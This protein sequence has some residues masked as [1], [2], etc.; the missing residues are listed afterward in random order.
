[1]PEDG[2]QSQRARTKQGKL[3]A[4]SSVSLHP[5]VPNLAERDWLVIGERGCPSLVTMT[6]IV[7]MM[8]LQ[9]I[10]TQA[11]TS[12]YSHPL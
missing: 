11:F 10:L 9:L 6:I 4:W 12:L 7:M 3:D 1:M 8:A 2:S 5:T